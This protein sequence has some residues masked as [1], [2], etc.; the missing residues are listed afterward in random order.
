MAEDICTG[1]ECAAVCP[2]YNLGGRCP[3][4]AEIAS[5]YRERQLLAAVEAGIH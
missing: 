4:P 2:V 5:W 3:E 1:G